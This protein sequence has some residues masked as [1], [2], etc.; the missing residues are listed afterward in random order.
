MAR[1][2]QPVAQ[3][4]PQP[5]PVVVQQPAPQPQAEAVPVDAPPPAAPVESPA[6]V[7]QTQAAAVAAAA[8]PAPAEQPTPAVARAPSAEETIA[9]M[10]PEN[11]APQL[12]EMV[13]FV[14]E[15]LAPRIAELL[16]QRR[17]EAEPANTI[18][19][20]LTR[21]D[22]TAHQAERARPRPVSSRRFAPPRALLG[23]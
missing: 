1:A 21:A 18:H 10:L 14:A 16:V 8:P 13:S 17:T 6:P 2:A 3:P 19:A 5:Q 22:D 7:E 11:A 9:R 4:D 15:T 12:F 20:T 23:D